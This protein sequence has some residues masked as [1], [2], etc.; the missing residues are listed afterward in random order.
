MTKPQAP[1]GKGRSE[2]PT[3]AAAGH[4]GSGLAGR[5]PLHESQGSEVTLR[6]GMVA[7]VPT[8]LDVLFALGRVLPAILFH[9][10]HNVLKALVDSDVWVFSL[11]LGLR[12]E[13]R[14]RMLLHR[15]DVRRRDV[16]ERGAFGRLARVDNQK[17]P[18]GIEALRCFLRDDGVNASP[19]GLP[20]V[21]TLVGK[22][23]GEFRTRVAIRAQKGFGDAVV[24]S[25][26]ENQVLHH[27]SEARHKKKLSSH[28]DF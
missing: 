17:P 16:R 21:F 13:V 9:D 1:D 7:H 6:L 8:P 22:V 3:S 2:R 20:C 23:P 26:F 12:D 11:G 4:R 14:P 25:A 27:E 28:L 10:I 19:I 15:R 18:N 24:S 5:L